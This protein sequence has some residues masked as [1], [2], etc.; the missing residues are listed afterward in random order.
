MRGNHLVSWDCGIQNS[1]STIVDG[2][3]PLSHRSPRDGNHAP[4]FFFTTL[5]VVVL[6]PLLLL[7]FPIVCCV[8]Y[9]SLRRYCLFIILFYYCDL[10][11]LLFP[12]VCFV[13]YCSLRRYCLF[14]ILFYYCDLVLALV[15]FSS[16]AGRRYFLS[17]CLLLG[18]DIF[19]LQ[20]P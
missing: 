8:A 6:L 15:L 3:F 11:L 13:A 19:R 17:R 1:R 9:C 16:P 12:I 14:I 5:I 2:C 4:N 7:L 18:R 10:V 20:T